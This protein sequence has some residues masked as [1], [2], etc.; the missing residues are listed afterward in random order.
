MAARDDMERRWRL[1]D[2][3]ADP[4][5]ELLAPGLDH[6]PLPR[7][8]PARPLGVKD[9]CQQD[10]SP[11][12][13]APCAIGAWLPPNTSDDRC[14]GFAIRYIPTYLCQPF[15]DDSA[16]LVRGEDAI[17]IS[18]WNPDDTGLWILACWRCTRQSPSARPKCRIEGPASKA[19]TT[20]ARPACDEGLR[21]RAQP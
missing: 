4:A 15:G 5:S 19:T 8:R 10:I 2:L 3:L 21:R 12:S 20:H 6:L 13:F 7:G 14:I 9:H 18:S 17:G 16:S 1:S 11:G